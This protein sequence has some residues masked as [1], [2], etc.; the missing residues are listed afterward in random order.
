MRGARDGRDASES[1]KGR[2]VALFA[3]R[4]GLAPLAMLVL[5]A[6]CGYQF[7]VE[8]PGPTIGPTKAGADGKPEK[9]PPRL[10]ILTLENK[11]F[12]P[13]LE[14]K[15]TGYIRHEFSTGSGT[16]VVADGQP[17]DMI[18]KGAIVMVSIPA[19]AFTQGATLENRVSV[20]VKASVEDTHT[21]KIVWDRYASA[22]SEFFVTND[23]QFNRVLQT[24]A[25]E[26]AGRLVAEDLATQF[27]SFVE[28]G[29]EPK[30][31]HAVP[32][33]LGAPMPVTPGSTQ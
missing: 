30:Q 28:V 7:Q 21:G 20:I 5:L 15:Y 31:T 9:P 27:L 23:L 8:G 17:A 14:V 13:N 33:P 19:L 18:L 2:K 1:M 16:T 25:L 32:L 11:A 12:E 6:A 22:S 24:R 26:Q 4:A 29:P 10:R 3:N